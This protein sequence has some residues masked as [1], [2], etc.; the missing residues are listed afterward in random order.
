MIATMEQI[1]VVGRRKNVQDV[2][3]SLQDLGAVHI[4]PVEGAPLERLRLSEE[5]RA[6]KEA[7]D[8]VV[9]RTK[10]LLTVLPKPAS[11]AAGG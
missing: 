6:A 10:T 1:L 2:L 8:A 11:P 7:W 5:D 3:M 9:A 4:D